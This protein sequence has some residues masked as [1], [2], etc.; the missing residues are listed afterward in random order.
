[1]FSQTNDR[2]NHVG[3]FLP[4]TI[5]THP[6]MKKTKVFVAT[7]ILASLVSVTAAETKPNIVFLFADDLGYGDLSC[8]AHPYARTPAIDQLGKEGTRFTQFYVT[9]VTCNPSPRGT[10]RVRKAT[11]H[12]DSA[13]V[14]SSGRQVRREISRSGG[15]R[16]FR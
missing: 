7:I 1:M 3:L 12:V 10:N 16:R 9:G 14:D 6:A 5:R 8:N 15:Q 4:H 2:S 11:H 13:Y